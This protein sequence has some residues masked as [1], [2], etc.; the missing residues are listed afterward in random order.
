MIWALVGILA[1][2]SVLNLLFAFVPPPMAVKGLFR[3]PVIFVFLP[4]RLILP[5][6]R[7]F[8]GLIGFVGTFFFALYMHR[9]GLM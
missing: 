1:V 5:V 3:V 9:A 6:G 8:N 2:W 7:V 4:D